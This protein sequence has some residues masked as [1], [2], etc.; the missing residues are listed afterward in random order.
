MMLARILLP[1]HPER[2]IEKEVPMH[3]HIIVAACSAACLFNSVPAAV[4]AQL[5]NPRTANGTTT[6]PPTTVAQQ[7]GTG[8]RAM[9]R[10][11]AL[12]ALQD[13]RVTLT[14]LTEASMSQKTREA[15]ARVSTEFRT[16]Y[17]PTRA[18]SRRRRRRRCR[19][20]HR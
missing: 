15:L 13:A 2:R 20:H 17:K 16:L 14:R 12:T 8:A 19:P 10:S 6:S 5:P 11:D 1:D 9:S 4:G 18:R 7:P 3:R